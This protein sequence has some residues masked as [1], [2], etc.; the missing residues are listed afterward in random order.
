MT[1]KTKKS[2][3]TCFIIIAISPLNHYMRLYTNMK[4]VCTYILYKV[5]LIPT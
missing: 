3:I 1:H 4:L 5:S 2:A